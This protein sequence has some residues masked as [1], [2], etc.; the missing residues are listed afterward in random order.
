MRDDGSQLEGLVAFVE[1][2]LLPQGFEVKTNRRVYNDEGVQI[3]EFDI[4][5]R[6]RLGTTDIAW[7]IECRDRPGSGPAPGSWIEQLVG[8][9]VRFG[10]NKVTA[11]S[12][13]GFAAGAEDFANREG[14]ELRHVESLSAEDFSSW[15]AIKHFCQ[16]EQRANLEKGVLFFEEG[17]SAKLLEKAKAILNSSDGNKK[18][19]RSVASNQLLT[20]AEAF[21]NVANDMRLFD[22]ISPC[23]RGKK[24]DLQV[25]YSN[26]NDHFVMDVEAESIRV[27]DIRFVGELLVVESNIPINL[28]AEYKGAE[29]G[30]ISQ[31]VSFSPWEVNGTTFSIELHRMGDGGETH[32]VMR[33]H[34]QPA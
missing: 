4:E 33:R 11:V 13:T 8:R 27:R 26:D 7:L 14:I 31:F 20:V 10:F 29:A 21:A 6:G 25:R 1:G 34:E 28:V 32:V 2:V 15:L 9:R 18:I 5:I 3:A 17:I 12:T 24:V 19:L 30:V 16:R 23:E 22:S